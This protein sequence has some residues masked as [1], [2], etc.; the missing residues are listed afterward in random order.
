MKP[1][2]SIL[3]LLGVTAYVALNAAVAVRPTSAWSAILFYAWLIIM[4]KQCLNAASDTSSNAVFARATLCGTIVYTVA[5]LVESYASVVQ[6]G[7][8]SLP[9]NAI[10]WIVLSLTEDD[11]D[12]LMKVIPQRVGYFQWILLNSGLACGLFV[13]SL[14]LWRYRRLERRDSIPPQKQIQTAPPPT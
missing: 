3:T 1:R 8:L 4:L 10:Y 5:A 7:D 12:S 13:G 6:P 2:F 11:A 14:A 9:H